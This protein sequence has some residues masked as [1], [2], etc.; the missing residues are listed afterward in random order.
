MKR[1]TSPALWLACV[2]ISGGLFFGCSDHDTADFRT[3]PA[4]PNPG[5]S[6]VRIYGGTGMD[7]QIAPSDNPPL[8][9]E[10]RQAAERVPSGAGRPGTT[11]YGGT[12]MGDSSVPADVGQRG[13]VPRTNEDAGAGDDRTR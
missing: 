8:T 5:D 1:L 10:E 6:G 3:E 7:P 4:G 13:G 12:G 11:V 9:A 2:V